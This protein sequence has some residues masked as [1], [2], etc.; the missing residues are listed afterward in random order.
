MRK[1]LMKVLFGIV[2][3]TAQNFTSWRLN[4]LLGW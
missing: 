1:S 4:N 2:E 3:T